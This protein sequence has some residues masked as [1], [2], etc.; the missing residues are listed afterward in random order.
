[1]CPCQG[2]VD[3]SRGG[4]GLCMEECTSLS[5]VLSLCYGDSPSWRPTPQEGLGYKAQ[6]P[7]PP[8]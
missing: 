4:V 6:R 3:L 1:M 5:I 7:V 2:G 8:K